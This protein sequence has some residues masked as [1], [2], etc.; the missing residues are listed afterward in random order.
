MM[1]EPSLPTKRTNIAII[2]SNF[3]VDTF[4]TAARGVEKFN[5]YAIYS[6]NKTTGNNK[7]K[8]F[9]HL[10]E[11][12]GVKVFTD[13]A[14]M[15]ADDNIDAIYIASPNSFHAKQ[16][17]QCLNAGK[18]VLG[19]KPSATNSKELSEILSAAIEN[20][21][22]F[23][24]AL[25]SL[26]LPNFSLLKQHMP[27]IGTPRKYFGQ[28]CQYSSRYNLALDLLAQ[29]KP[30]HVPN[31]FLP[32]F[33]NGALIDIGIYPLYPVV[34]LWGEPKSI[35]AQGVML[36]TGVD[37]AGDLQLDYDDKVA[38]I[39]F[40]KIC[41]GENF[42]EF[43]G[44]LGRLR[45]EF[46][47]LM[48]KVELFLNDGSYELLCS[49]DEKNN[50]KY[51]QPMS[52]EISHFIELVQ[53]HQKLAKSVKSVNIEVLQSKVTSWQLSQ[54]V[55]AIIDQARGKIGVVYPND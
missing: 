44:E 24:E 33:G 48:R 35:S 37:G 42:V 54:Q 5:F 13:L 38:T 27:R 25:M 49:N 55:I 12:M 14:I 41:N 15:L 7:A 46:V 18:H 11:E 50:D 34:A 39:S 2:G 8:Q 16:A 45:V 19:E 51:Y 17:I 40:S 36:E 53:N 31:T 43:Q 22:C 23:M 32:E 30:E 47:S 9:S 3:I 10:N 21:R 4:L 1:T 28:Y 52:Y 6:R 29:K 20:N 26:H